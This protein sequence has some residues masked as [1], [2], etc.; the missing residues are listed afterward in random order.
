[1]ERTRASA[2][3]ASIGGARV[4]SSY[5]SLSLPKLTASPSGERKSRSRMHIAVS[6]ARSGWSVDCK[7][8]ARDVFLKRHWNR[9]MLSVGFSRSLFRSFSKRRMLVL[10]ASACAENLWR[11]LSAKRMS[12]NASY[13]DRRGGVSERHRFLS[14]FSF[15]SLCSS[16]KKTDLFTV[17]FLSFFLSSALLSFLLKKKDS[18]ARHGRRSRDQAGR[19]QR[20][21]E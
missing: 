14:F 16:E 4:S 2:A 11:S 10:D 1:M 9:S 15:F 21:R 12:R 7:V 6:R 20:L 3:W 5:L 8:G 13:L 19:G 18:R 17:F